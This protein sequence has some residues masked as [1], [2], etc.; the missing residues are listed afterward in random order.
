MLLDEPTDNLDLVSAEALKTGLEAYEGT[1]LAATHDRWF[2]KSFG[3]F[4]IFG[5]DG[6][7]REAPEPAW[8]EGRVTR[9]R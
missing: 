4:V 1:V 6:R 9:K 8:D 3:R 5:S 7:L 2:A